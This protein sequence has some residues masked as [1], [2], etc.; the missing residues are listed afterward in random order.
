MQE[1]R[2]N[3][4]D[5]ISDGSVTERFLRL[6]MANQ[7]R[8]Y[9]YILTLVPNWSDADDIMQEVTAVMWRKF[10]K[11]KRGTDFAAWGVSIAHYE[12]LKFR[13]KNRHNHLHLN[14]KLLEDIAE[15]CHETRDEKEKRLRALQKCLM[16]LSEQDRR[17]IKLRYEQYSTSK[18]VAERV[19]RS[20]QGIYKTMARIHYTL[21][22]C[23]RRVLVMEDTP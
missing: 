1:E 19:G 21:Q 17:L 9:A 16:K 13:K 4:T 20:V 3:S 23:V 18:R 5:S 11:F 14:E 2:D 12:V 15:K 22:Q 8:V 6:L 7:N 10:D